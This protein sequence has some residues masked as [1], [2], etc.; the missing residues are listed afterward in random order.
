[1]EEKPEG[2]YSNNKWVEIMRPNTSGEAGSI[3]NMAID[4]R[5]PIIVR[6]PNNGHPY[7]WSVDLHTNVNTHD[8]LNDAIA[9][10]L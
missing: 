1:M 10:F 2:I 9:V 4:G 5:Y 3:V 8:S 6:S 7:W